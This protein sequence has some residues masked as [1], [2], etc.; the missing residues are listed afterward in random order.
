[1][2]QSVMPLEASYYVSKQAFGGSRF[3]SA[4]AGYSSADMFMTSCCRLPKLGEPLE[5]GNIFTLRSAR[6]VCQRVEHMFCILIQP[7]FLFDPM[8]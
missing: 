1:M 8:L 2:P 3:R 5:A 7:D 4:F 6:T